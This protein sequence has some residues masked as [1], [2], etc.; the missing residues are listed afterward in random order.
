M[1]RELLLVRGFHPRWSGEGP[2]GG[3]DLTF[4]ELGSPL[5]GSK[6]RTWLVSCKDYSA[7]G[8]AVGQGALDGCIEAVRQHDA[9]GFLLVCTTHPS[10]SLVKRMEE[11]ERR[12]IGELAFHCWDAVDLERLLSTPRGWS[13]AQQFMPVSTE[14]AGW[15]FFATSDPR[16]WYTARRG[17]YFEVASRDEG[18]PY[19]DTQSFDE[20]LNEME[21]AATRFAIKIRPQGV[22]H[23]D[24]YGGYL[25]RLDYFLAHDATEAIKEEQLLAELQD[26]IARKDGQFHNFQLKA[27]QMSLSDAFNL[28]NHDYYS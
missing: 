21:R 19:F 28:D 27:R 26:G 4:T 17:Y 22:W 18:G 3:R 20:R 11:L 25:W 15:R 24:R 9:Q 8:K 7:S 5:L 1:V 13:L 14:R 12:N 6:P 23:N 2:D 10:A 16:Y